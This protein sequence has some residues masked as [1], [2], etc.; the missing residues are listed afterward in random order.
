MKQ[1]ALAKENGQP[2]PKRLG[3]TENIVVALANDVCRALAHLHTADDRAIV[4][5]DLKPDNV[6]L[7][8]CVLFLRKKLKLIG[9]I[10]A[11]D[12]RNCVI[13]AWPTLSVADVDTHSAARRGTWR[14]SC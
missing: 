7:T 12:M 1:Q 14:P 3:L 5:R 13:L 9:F 10:Q 4:H 2:K 6:L 11:T 8:R